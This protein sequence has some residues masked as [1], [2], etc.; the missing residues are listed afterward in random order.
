MLR[1]L[2]CLVLAVFVSTLYAAPISSL[3]DKL[4]KSIHL[5]QLVNS[6]NSSR[7]KKK[8]IFY[9]YHANQDLD[10]LRRDVRDWT[11]INSIEISETDIAIVEK[12]FVKLG[13]TP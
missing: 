3:A 11:A 8:P 10:A 1:L 7:R 13:F 12:V 2:F 4:V 5:V 6:V 9:L